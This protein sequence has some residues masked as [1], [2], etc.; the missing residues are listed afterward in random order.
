MLSKHGVTLVYEVEQLNHDEAVQLFSWNAFKDLKNIYIGLA[1]EV[2]TYA[3][4]LPLALQLL[5]SFMEKS[6]NDWSSAS[7]RFKEYPIKK[8]RKRERHH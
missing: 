4:G 6:T 2:L 7:N 1:N 8:K 5:G 3:K